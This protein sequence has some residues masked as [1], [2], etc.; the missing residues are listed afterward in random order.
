MIDERLLHRVKIP[1]NGG[2]SF[3]R[4]HLAPVRLNGKSQALGNAAA[5][6]MHGAC[7]A[8]AM[9]ATLLGAGQGKPFAQYI[10]ERRARIERQSPG[11]SI[12]DHAHRDRGSWAA[13]GF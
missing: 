10:Q 1:V 6:E 11:R 8:L 7:A 4:G 3:D 2:E 9:I 13:G 12:H 5:V